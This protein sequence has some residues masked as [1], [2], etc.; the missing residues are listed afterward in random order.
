MPSKF[1]N[2]SRIMS[3]YCQISF[4]AS[5]GWDFVSELDSYCVAELQFW[6]SSIKKFNL[7]YC[8]QSLSHN[9]IVYS[10]ASGLACGVIILNNDT[11]ICHRLFT[12]EERAFS[13]THRE[14]IAIE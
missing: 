2:L 5:P 10:D 14:F 7:K 9:Q 4:T 12:Q 13:S 1:G 6:F 3:R 11:H 8:F